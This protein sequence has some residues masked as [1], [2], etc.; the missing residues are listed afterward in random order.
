MC[1]APTPFNDAGCIVRV[2]NIA[3]VSIVDGEYLVA[4]GCSDGVLHVWI[5]SNNEFRRLRSL[6]NHGRCIL[7]VELVEIS[8]G[9]YCLLSAGTD[10]RVLCWKVVGIEVPDEP[11]I[12]YQAHQSGVNGM[13]TT[14]DEGIL[15]IM[16]GGDDCSISIFTINV[17]GEWMLASHG[18]V[19]LAHSSNVTGVCCIS[20]DSFISCSIDQ[21]LHV[22][23]I[24]Q[25]EDR[26]ID[27]VK[28][29]TIASCVPDI[30]DMSLS[31]DVDG[32]IVAVCGVGAQIVRI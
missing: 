5:Y 29:K 31:R 23:R 7:K 32:V 9:V 15:S 19:D 10:G 16:S 4:A 3:A 27:L 14:L 18:R 13:D 6:N 2:M 8:Q 24:E 28:T 22:W 26:S 20:P 25:R 30:C 1:F 17:Q 11:T 21:D 12:I